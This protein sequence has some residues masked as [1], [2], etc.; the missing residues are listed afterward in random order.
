[1]IPKVLFF[2]QV[3]RRP[4]PEHYSLRSATTVDRFRE[5]MTTLKET[6]HPLRIE[7]FVWIYHNGRRWPRRSV[8]ITFDDGFK[9]N[10]WAAEVL[11]ELGMEAT[12][13]I[14]SGAVGTRFQ[15]WYVRFSELITSRQREVFRCS[16]GEVDFQNQ[17]SRRRWQKQTKEH[18]LALR[19]AARDAALDELAA[20]AGSPQT[21]SLDPDLEFLNAEDLKR[22]LER[23]MVLGA[24]SRTHDNL[25]ACDAGELRSEIIDCR[26][27]L[28]QLTG[29]PVRYFCYPDGRYSAGALDLVRQNFDAAFTIRSGYTAPDLWRFPRRSADGG[30]NLGKVLSPWYPIRGKMVASAKR[31]L[32]F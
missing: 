16:W 12:F 6:C 32:G 31:I 10:L 26:D 5:M 21:E 8:L 23:G 11:Q 30:A 13:F 17:F 28:A 22:L 27:E 9:N 24:H 2:H 4:R 19:P 15:P 25:A 14:V 7:E 3:V 18:L 20:A 1:M 29:G